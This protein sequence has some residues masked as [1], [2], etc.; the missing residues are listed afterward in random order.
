MLIP[1]NPASA[2]GQATSGVVDAT[3]GAVI[4]AKTAFPFPTVD[5][6][7]ARQGTVAEQQRQPPAVRL[8]IDGMLMNGEKPSGV[9]LGDGVVD[10]TLSERGAA[11][12]ARQEQAAEA[13]EAKQAACA[14][15]EVAE[16]LV[17]VAA[18]SMGLTIDEAGAAAGIAAIS[19]VTYDP[20]DVRPTSG[21]PELL[22]QDHDRKLS[23]ALAGAPHA[24]LHATEAAAAIGKEAAAGSPEL[25]AALQA[26][27]SLPL[28]TPRAILQDQANQ[29]TR[30]QLDA[31]LVAGSPAAKKV[32]RRS[33]MPM[34]QRLRVLELVR[35]A[36]VDKPD[37]ELAADISLAIDR[38]VGS[39]TIADYRKQLGLASVKM[40]SKSELQ[41]KLRALE[42]KLAEAQQPGLPA[43]PPPV[44]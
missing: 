28:D 36:P 43:V 40:P 8:P 31:A 25:N 30:A 1:T 39:S 34:V 22:L 26:I 29:Q 20:Q 41:A 9:V 10:S 14:T 12:A 37:A 19:T 2:A 4:G 7:R 33:P 23:Q 18:K 11:L 21:S 38:A 24:K 42:A 13:G 6:L 44:I 17:A 3:R 27:D 16:K 35:A 15:T 5:E 32:A